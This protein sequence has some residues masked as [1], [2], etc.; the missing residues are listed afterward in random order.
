MNE[1][2]IRR[3]L[4]TYLAE[5]RKIMAAI[6]DGAPLTGADRE[7]VRSAVQSLKER[8]RIDYKRLPRT[9]IESELFS[10]AMHKLFVALQPIRVNT[11]PGRDWFSALYSAET[12]L[13]YS[14]GQLA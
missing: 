11:A 13:V 8:V 14:L 1:T 4:E 5:V 12:E 2:E 3:V 7:N 6:P 9:A 10:P